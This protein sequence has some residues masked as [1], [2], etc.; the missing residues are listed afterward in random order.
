MSGGTKPFNQIDYGDRSL[1][2][3]GLM[4]ALLVAGGALQQA[5]GEKFDSLRY[6]YE[7]E[8][9]HKNHS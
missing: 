2:V 4:V 3:L 8:K 1:C 9:G 7:E 5:D 6:T